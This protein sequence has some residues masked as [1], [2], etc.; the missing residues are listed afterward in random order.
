MPSAFTNFEIVF[1]STLTSLLP[2]MAPEVFDIFPLNE[3]Y[4]LFNT[5]KSTLNQK[6]KE[7]LIK[8]II[9]YKQDSKDLELKLM[10]TKKL[11]LS[12]EKLKELKMNEK[13]EIIELENLNQK[14]N[15]LNQKLIKTETLLIKLQNKVKS[16]GL[17]IA[18]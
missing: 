2:V 6:S 3:I 12:K 7:D 18:G 15:L 1:P 13:N 16:N 5:L 4:L 9:G 11:K 8:L 17:E 14:L 10:Q